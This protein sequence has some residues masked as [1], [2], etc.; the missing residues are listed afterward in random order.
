LP[1]AAALFATGC[2]DPKEEFGKFADRVVDAA[3]LSSTACPVAGFFPMNGEFLLSIQTPVGG[4]LRLV[5]TATTTETHPGGTVDL[6]F[7]PLVATNCA[8]G[9]GGD[10]AQAGQPVGDELP[11]VSGIALGENGT[12]DFS[13]QGATTPGDANAVLCGMDILA[14]IQFQGCTESAEFVCGQVLGMASKPI[15]LPLAGSTFGAVK[16]E[17]GAR[18]DD[19]LPDPVIACPEES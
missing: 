3:P 17:T 16:I 2:V 11:A 4:P 19:N 12:F 14:D 1:V 10:P 13:Q 18:G 8:N 7:Q 15:P 5:V 6:R 9:P